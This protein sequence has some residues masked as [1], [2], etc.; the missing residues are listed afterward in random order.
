MLY[1]GKA[2]KAYQKPVN[3]ARR[4]MDLENLIN[5]A[6]R[7]YLDN[8]MAVIYKKPTPVEI[9]KVTYK[10][11]T[12]YI[13]G[14][15]R[16]KSTLDYTGVYKGYYLDFD[17]K[18]SKS[19]TSFPLA[20]IHK[21]QF[22][23][24]KRVLKHGGISFLILQMNDRFFILEGNV[25]MNFVNNNER[26]SIPFEFIESNCLEIKLKF[27]PT[28]D[29]LNVLDKLISKKEEI[30]WKR[31]NLKKELIRQKKKIKLLVSLRKAGRKEMCL[32]RYL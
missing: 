19:K 31:L 5:E 25:L 16:E 24:M 28:L 18:S 23:H 17:A 22:L 30:L 20:N 29:Y 13:E 6:N 4:G 12:E 2:K 10:G 21:H 32:R 8:D 9:K 1:P 26:K 27:S 14:V 11:K 3:Y 7:Y 15:L